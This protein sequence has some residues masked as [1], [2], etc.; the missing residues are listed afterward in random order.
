MKH[1]EKDAQKLAV[2][3]V[4]LWKSKQAD[5]AKALCDDKIQA[6]LERYA[7]TT[8][9]KDCSRLYRKAIAIEAGIETKYRFNDE[10]MSLFKV[11]I[12]ITAGVNDESRDT[13]EIQRSERI[14]LTREILDRLLEV[15]VKLV[16]TEVK[17]GQD[18]YN[19]AVGLALL[20]GRRMYAEVLHHAYFEPVD[21]FQVF[22]VG[23]AK[24]GAEKREAGY[25]IPVL[26]CKSDVIANAQSEVADYI[27]SRGWY[28]AHFS[29]KDISSRCKKQVQQ[30]ITANIDSIF[31][32]IRQA[33]YSV[34]PIHPH[35][36]RKI[37]AFI[38]WVAK[39]GQRAGFTQFAPKILGHS[40][41]VKCSGKTRVNTRSS[42]S[43][44][45][46]RLVEYL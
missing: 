8:V 14:P 34:E 27:K 23:Q 41:T 33:G 29:D 3:V 43:Y 42:E 25:I 19:K 45:K 13:V 17:T 36:L 21:D 35:D 20:T 10:P 40:Y 44:E 24:G 32:P 26:G 11:P 18:I 9:S 37:Y 4:S 31:N 30:S 16:N 7:D 46:F 28:E 38:V 1:L 12:E 22:F 39:N 5:K 15:G 2:E 6:L